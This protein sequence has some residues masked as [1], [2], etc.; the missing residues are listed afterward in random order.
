MSEITSRAEALKASIAKWVDIR[1]RI[2]G[3]QNDIETMCGFCE[4]AK[5]KTEGVLGVGCKFCE[6]DA[7]K[8]CEEYITEE[9]LIV[10]PLFEAWEKTDMLLK[11]L[12]S[13]PVDLK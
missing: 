13:L 7:K 3:I 12:R 8:L 10:N 4:L 2:E 1:E 11:Q 9:R 6:A 5:K